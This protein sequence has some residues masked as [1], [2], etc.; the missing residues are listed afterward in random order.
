MSTARRVLFVALNLLGGVLVCSRGVAAQGLPPLDATAWPRVFY[1]SRQRAEIVRKRLPPDL[2]AAAQ[3][4]TIDPDTLPPPTFTLDGLAHGQLGASAIING[5]WYRPGD[6]LFG[7][8]LKIESNQVV[9]TGVDVPILKIKP[10]Q[11]VR[12]DNGAASESVPNR[13]IKYGTST[14][15]T[16]GAVQP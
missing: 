7:W 16:A 3:A 2:R 6:K 5:R 8:T 12:I 4:P 1:D 11:S 14:P 10:G 9:L 15:V 13:A